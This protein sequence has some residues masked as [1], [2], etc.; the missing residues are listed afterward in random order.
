[1]TISALAAGCIIIHKLCQMRADKS[2][3]AKIFMDLNWMICKSSALRMDKLAAFQMFGLCLNW[4]WAFKKHPRFAKIFNSGFV[5]VH[6]CCRN[7]VLKFTFS[8][9][10]LD[11]AAEWFFFIGVT[12]PA[13]VFG[14]PFGH[15]VLFLFCAVILFFY[16][17]KIVSFGIPST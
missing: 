11:H 17:L 2:N 16:S 6:R 14:I 5:T 8:Y 3:F 9:W 13:S 15:L 4:I 12:D 7:S 1:M 10:R